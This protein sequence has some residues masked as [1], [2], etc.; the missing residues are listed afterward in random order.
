MWQSIL[1]IAG[2]LAGAVVAGL[3]QQ[4]ATRTAQ[5]SEREAELRRERLTAVKELA[6]AVADHRRAMWVREEARDGSTPETRLAELRAESHTTRSAITAPH[7]ALRVL[8]QDPAVREA[9]ERAIQAT[10]R[11]REAHGLAELREM[12]AAAVD[13]ETAFVDAAGRYLT[14]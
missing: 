9:A 11:M 2:T 12:R 14:N 1:A 3:L 4:R 7:T 13:A 8:V 5:S 10:Y 6:A